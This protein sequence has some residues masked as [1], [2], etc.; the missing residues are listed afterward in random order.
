MGIADGATG[1]GTK[2]P[3]GASTSQAQ[4]NLEGN[5][6]GTLP[7]VQRVWYLSDHTKGSNLKLV[8]PA[9]QHKSIILYK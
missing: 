6:E 3:V 4:W 5:L 8:L 9:H 7:K 2:V 1:L